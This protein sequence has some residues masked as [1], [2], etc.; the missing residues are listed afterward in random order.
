MD[1]PPATGTLT[2]RRLDL[3]RSIRIYFHGAV[4]FKIPCLCAVDQSLPLLAWLPDVEMRHNHRRAR[5]EINLDKILVLQHP[6]LT[7][8]PTPQLHFEFFAGIF[9]AR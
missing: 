6:L 4:C 2:R 8:F 5:L 9:R 3:R 7:S 1:M